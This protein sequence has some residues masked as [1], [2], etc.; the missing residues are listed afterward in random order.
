M[1]NSTDETFFEDAHDRPLLSD[2]GRRTRRDPRCGIGGL[3]S[4]PRADELK[5]AHLGRDEEANRQD[6]RAK[7]RAYEQVAAFFHHVPISIPLPVKGGND[8]P[9]DERE[10][11][12]PAVR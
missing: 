3:G 10:P 4:G 2:E 12:L 1:P 6:A 7:S 8:R 5:D 9:A 11:D